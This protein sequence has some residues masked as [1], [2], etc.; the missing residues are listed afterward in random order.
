M[1]S[2][3]REIVGVENTPS[4]DESGSEDSR[5]PLTMFPEAESTLYNPFYRDCEL[6]LHQPT[7]LLS[8]KSLLRKYKELREKNP[9]RLKPSDFSS[10]NILGM[11]QFGYRRHH[12]RRRL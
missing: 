6:D 9:V 3:V 7:E 4:S 8:I 11:P 2:K 10:H 12:F 5:I 1:F